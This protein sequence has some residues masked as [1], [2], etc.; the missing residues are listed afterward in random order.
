MASTKNKFRCK[1]INFED[2]EFM[3]K[4]QIEIKDDS[5]IP[6]HHYA[7]KFCGEISWVYGITAYGVEHVNWLLTE[8]ENIIE[9]QVGCY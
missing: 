2:R 1:V 9:W 3:W 8:Q 5:V 4:I 7:C 6:F